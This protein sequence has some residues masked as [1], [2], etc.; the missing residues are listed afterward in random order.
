MND[1][2]EQVC[3]AVKSRRTWKVLGEQS[4]AID[5]Q[6]IESQDAIVER[7]IATAGF[8]PFHYDRDVDSVREPWRCY[9]LKNEVCR[10]IAGEL[11]AWVAGI[12]PNNKMPAM[13][14]ACGSLVLVTWLPQFADHGND[15]EENSEKQR[16]VDEEHL[17]AASAYVQSLLLLLT[18]AGLGTYWSSGGLMRSPEVFARLGVGSSERLLAA[19]FVDYL[20]GQDEGVQRIA[21]KHHPFRSPAEKWCRAITD[22]NE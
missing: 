4:I 6:V 3:K 10:Q 9:W 1:E 7:A 22:L 16:Q 21:G 13:L 2:F 18:A 15:D 8:A 19:V 17:A 12:K 14:S 5:A 11:P 20:P